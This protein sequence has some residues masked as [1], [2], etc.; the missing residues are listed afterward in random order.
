MANLR[1]SDVRGHQVGGELHATEA[2]ADGVGQ[3]ANHERLGQTRDA[4][5]QAMAAREDGDEQLFEDALLADD[6]LAQLLANA[7]IA[8]VEPLDGRQVAFD[9]RPRRCSTLAT[10]RGGRQYR[11]LFA[12]GQRYG[13][14]GSGNIARQPGTASAQS[15]AARRDL[16]HQ[17]AVDAAH[18][19]SVIAR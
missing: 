11:Y 19:H 13:C 1:A 5:Q 3:R 8:V 17:A 15:A 14:L 9:A 10:S 7:A 18:I 2:Q 16:H 4:N 12:L 6:G